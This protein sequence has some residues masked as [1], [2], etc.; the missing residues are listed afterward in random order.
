MRWLVCGGRD[1]GDLANYRE[2]QHHEPDSAVVRQKEKE[3][4]FILRTLNRLSV[5]RSSCFNPDDNWLPSDIEII[6]GMARGAD[7]VAVDWA[8]VNWCKWHEFPANWELYG[9]AAG[10]IR[11]RRMLDEGKPD[12]VVAFPGGKGTKM[13]VDLAKNA[14]VEVLEYRI[15]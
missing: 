11:N 2:E 8:V 9:K 3:Y 5:E 4:N 15:G 1:F 12:L 14:G 13:M 10:F 6:S 7:K